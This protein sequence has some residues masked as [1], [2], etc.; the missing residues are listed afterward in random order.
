MG[1]ENISRGYRTLMDCTNGTFDW[2]KEVKLPMRETKMTFV[3]ELNSEEGANTVSTKE[4]NFPVNNKGT[5]T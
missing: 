3:A 2:Q 4:W 5:I 1:L